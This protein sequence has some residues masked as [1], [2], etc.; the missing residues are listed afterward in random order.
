MNRGF[1]LLKDKFSDVISSISDG[2]S[3]LQHPRTA[4]AYNVDIESGEP[5]QG[6]NQLL[7]QQVCKDG[8]Y[9]NGFVSFSHAMKQGLFVKA[10]EKAMLPM[11][12]MNSR[13][14]PEP[15]LKYMYNVAQLDGK[16]RTYNKETKKY[17][18]YTAQLMNS[19][20]V[21]ALKLNESPSFVPTSDK[22]MNKFYAATLSYLKAV[23]SVADFKPVAF[24]KPEAQ[25]I[26]DFYSKFPEQVLTMV[27]TLSA[28]LIHKNEL[29]NVAIKNRGS[30][31]EN[32]VW[33]R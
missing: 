5:L 13:N 2:N 30:V 4:K 11:I 28:S 7:S 6:I 18:I 8:N 20:P 21:P 1:V 14:F 27:N 29:A 12:Y 15:T 25:T 3:V 19:I 32:K 9:S 17:E 33:D 23:Y 24:T 10:N 22:C 16:S 31:R 26:K